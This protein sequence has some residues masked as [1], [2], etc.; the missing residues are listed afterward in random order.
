VFD[1]TPPYRFTG[2]VNHDG[3]LPEWKY[4]KIYLHD[5]LHRD[6]LERVLE[7]LDHHRSEVENWFFVRYSTAHGSPYGI[8][9]R[10][11]LRCHDGL[12]S[13]VRR[14]LVAMTFGQATP[15]LRD[16][17]Y[18][19]E[20]DRYGGP[21]GLAAAH[22]IFTLDSRTVI[23]LLRVERNLAPAIV[24]ASAW[25]FLV[26]LG[27]RSAEIDD[28]YDRRITNT[29]R[30]LN[31]TK[32]R[33]ADIASREAAALAMRWP[34]ALAT[35]RDHRTADPAASEWQNSAKKLREAAEAGLLC[36]PLADIVLD[37]QHMHFNR[38][39]IDA[40]REL[41]LVLMTRNLRSW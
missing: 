1:T 10:L 31:S 12:F 30:R 41:S 25:Q 16:A 14:R 32:S 20:L 24:A 22:D 13:E 33:L 27:M 7:V 21:A 38:L 15:I 11:R 36:R 9:V 2:A 29:A 37:L 3:D 40:A 6:F 8:E 35:V 39:G 19:P 28:V 26:D 5:H 18:E 17:H 23:G 34:A 4:V